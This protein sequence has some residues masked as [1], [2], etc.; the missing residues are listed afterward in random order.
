MPVKLEIENIDEF[1]G[2]LEN[3][4]RDVRVVVAQVHRGIAAYAFNYVLDHSAQFSGDFCR[5]WNLSIGAPNYAYV[6]TTQ[7]TKVPEIVQR[8]L[9]DAEA[10][11][12]AKAKAAGVLDR[13]VVGDTIFLANGSTHDEPYAWLIEENQI[14]FRPGNYGR[15]VGNFM[16]FAPALYADINATNVAGIIAMGKQL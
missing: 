13:S 7:N 4:V 6:D 8:V 14:K 1:I 15:P 11:Q 10:I 3:W 12:A 16:D 9:G 5:N 2:E